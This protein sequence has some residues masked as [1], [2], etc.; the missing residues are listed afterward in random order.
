MAFLVPG[1]ETGRDTR[2]LVAGAAN[3][4]GV[5]MEVPFQSGSFLSRT[6]I[7]KELMAA[8]TDLA[9]AQEKG[10]NAGIEAAQKKI[11]DL[12]QYVADR[13]ARRATELG[14]APAEAKKAGEAAVKKLMGQLDPI[15]YGIG[16]SVTPE[17]LSKLEA[18]IG[19]NPAI[20][21][22]RAAS[23]AIVARVASRR[24]FRPTRSMVSPL[25]KSKLPRVKLGRSQSR[26]IR[27]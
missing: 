6:P 23:K 26:K 12:T 3:A 27:L 13:A 1:S 10:D 16:R 8:G 7:R 22:D 9:T 19:Q 21:R 20:Q 5:R 25:R 18:R 17:E 14:Q 2:S 15:R 11:D 4:A 24:R